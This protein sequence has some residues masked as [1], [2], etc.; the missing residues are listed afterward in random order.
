MWPA[1]RRVVAAEPT[2]NLLLHSEFLSELWEQKLGERRPSPEMFV[3]KIR[4][5]LSWFWNL[6]G[7]QIL[8]AHQTRISTSLCITS[9]P[10]MHSQKKPAIFNRYKTRDSL[11]IRTLKIA[12]RIQGK[13]LVMSKV[14]HRHHQQIRAKPYMSE[15]P[16]R[17]KKESS[18]NFIR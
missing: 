4:N 12:Y 14:S 13:R 10:L 18:L 11:F 5:R 2:W 1:G 15:D 17:R 6:T 3:I 16:S 9:T 8:C 7:H